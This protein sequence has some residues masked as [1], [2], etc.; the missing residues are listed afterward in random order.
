M[1]S[2]RKERIGWYFYDWANSAFY[3]TVVTVFLGP[4]LKTITQA[5]AD[6]AGYVYP[7]GIPVYYKSFFFYIL[8][9]SFVCQFLL[10]PILGAIADYTNKKKFL[11]GLFAY[12]GS[13]STMGMYF[14]K[15]DNYL[16]GGVLLLMANVWFGA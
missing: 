13:V 16:L 14:L 8:A 7:L 5:A 2:T 3:T 11:L 12:M 6:A 10:L 15:G 1:Q 4:Y 9:F